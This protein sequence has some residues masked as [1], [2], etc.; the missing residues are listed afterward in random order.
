V[1]PRSR[2]NALRIPM[3]CTPLHLPDI[4]S[5]SLTTRRAMNGS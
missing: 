1:T 2:H 4:G 5:A 3:H